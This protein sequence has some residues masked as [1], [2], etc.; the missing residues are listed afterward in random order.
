M[1]YGLKIINMYI[2]LSPSQFQKPSVLVYLYTCCLLLI[3]TGICLLLCRASFCGVTSV[4]QCRAEGHAAVSRI[5]KQSQKQG[6]LNL[7]KDTVQNENTK[8][9]KKQVLLMN[10]IAD[11]ATNCKILCRSPFQNVSS[12]RGEKKHGSNLSQPL[13][14]NDHKSNCSWQKMTGVKHREKPLIMLPEKLCKQH[15]P[16]FHS[17]PG[18]NTKNKSPVTSNR[19]NANSLPPPSNPPVKQNMPANWNVELTQISEFFSR[20]PLALFR[21]LIQ[22]AFI[23]QTA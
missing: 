15:T 23:S 9:F 7:P 21:S 5:D 3:L 17:F 6:N 14:R 4:V 18:W 13:W 16:L 11:L 20:P 10:K 2:V 1:I 19:T 8:G 22:V 12:P